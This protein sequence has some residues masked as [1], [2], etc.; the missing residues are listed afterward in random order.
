MPIFDLIIPRMGESIEEATLIRWHKAEGDVVSKDDVIADIATDKV[1]TEL[2]TPVSGK[3]QSLLY[4]PNDVVKVGNIIAKIETSHSVHDGIDM[5]SI[6]FPQEEIKIDNIITKV[7]IN[8]DDRLPTVPFVPDSSIVKNEKDASVFFSPLVLKIAQEENIHFEELKDIKGTGYEGRITK[9]DVLT[10]IDKKKHTTLIA[11]V[12]PPIMQNAPI[13][14]ASHEHKREM[15]IPMDR[16]RKLIAKNLL[17]SITT[18][19]HV[20]SIHEADVSGMVKWRT[21]YKKHFQE[22]EQLR[23]TFTPMIIDCLVKVL[24]QFPLMNASVENDN[25]IIKKEYH[26]G[27]ATALPNGNLMVPVVKDANLL[28]LKGLC[29]EVHQLTTAAREGRLLPDYLANGTFT[30]SNVGSIGSLMG[31]P[32]IPLPQVAI[33][34]VGMIKK[35]PIVVETN[36][37]DT[38]AIREMIY[39]SMSYDHRIIDGAMG[40]CF[41]SALAKELESWNIER[42]P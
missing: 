10:Y 18:S 3:I 12:A 40:S 9:K 34:S 36:L 14:H 23:L 26:I 42:E 22:K 17:D 24:P 21:K 19:V 20:T 30:F 7:E 11:S 38:I 37:G 13:A 41:L 33:L 35:R 6:I 32:I 4:K 2:P 15:I 27:V 29:K 25:I 8:D 31:T 16:V 1:D 5:S 39:L 28:N